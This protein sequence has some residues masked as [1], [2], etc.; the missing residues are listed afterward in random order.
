MLIIAGWLR[1]DPAHRD[2]YLRLVAD[3]TA[4]ARRARGCLAFVQAPDPIEADRIVIFERWA[5]E[6]DLL[7]FRDQ[8]TDDETDEALPPIL[9]A[10]VR[11]Y[12]ISAEGPP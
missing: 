1:V 12:E 3:V 11:R 8:P 9:G 4:E 2:E 7:A 6:A 5:S 10:D